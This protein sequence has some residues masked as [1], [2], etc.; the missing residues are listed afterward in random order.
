MDIKESRLSGSCS[1][2]WNALFS[3]NTDGSLNAAVCRVH[4][5]EDL[6]MNNTGD[7]IG[8]CEQFEKIDSQGKHCTVEVPPCC[9]T[10]TERK[11][12]QDGSAC[13]LR[14]QNFC[15]RWL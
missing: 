7:F 1:N 11:D 12:R 9:S 15:T 10:C 5:N 14:V 13:S 3:W 6:E 8:L 4:C 2:C